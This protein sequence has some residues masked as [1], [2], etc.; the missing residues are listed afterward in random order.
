MNKTR[1]RSPAQRRSA[2]EWSR[3]VEAWKRSGLDADRFAGDRGVSARSLRWWHWRLRQREKDDARS[4]DLRLVEVRVEEDRSASSNWPAWEVI[5][6][7]GHV[8]RVHCDREGTMLDR[9]LG[10]L[11]RHER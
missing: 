7:G 4:E 1:P 10:H 5:T 9:V 3:L 11:V 2:H 6:A 8:L